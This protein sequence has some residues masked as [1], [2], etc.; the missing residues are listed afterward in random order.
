MSRRA[1]VLDSGIGGLAVVREL[2]RQ[3]AAV[4]IAYVADD[5]A[6]PYGDIPA[7]DLTDHVVALV[8][9][10]VPETSPDVIVIAC[11]TA[12]T[13]VLPP[14][15]ARFDIPIVG[16]VPAV[17]PA[18]ER[19]RSRAFSVL[20]TPGTIARDYT[21]DLVAQHAPACRV[22]LVGAAK[23]AEIAEARMAGRAVDDRAITAEIAAAF[24]ETPEGRTDAVV[25][26][27]THYAFLTD[28][29]VRLAP[30]P[31]EWIDPSPAIA[32]RALSLLHGEAGTPGR[33]TAVRT[34]GTAWPEGLRPLLDEIALEPAV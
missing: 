34:S 27:C 20:A 17:K 7:D 29:L 24:V 3:D 32:R 12:S 10:L 25:L 30:W 18:A 13:L 8:E 21:R 6:F 28:E 15:R 31:V 2:R 14:L 1:L 11:N 19:S 5:A 4:E 23:L 26:G 22:T 33:G 9:R 16:T